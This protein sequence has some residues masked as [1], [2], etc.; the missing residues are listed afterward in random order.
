MF[1]FDSVVGR[2]VSEVYG[3]RSSGTSRMASLPRPPV[4]RTAGR[5][6]Y[7][8]E[9][10]GGLRSGMQ[11]RLTDGQSGKLTAPFPGCRGDGDW[12]GIFLDDGSEANIRPASVA[13]VFEKSGWRPFGGRVA[14]P[15]E[16][17][18]T[19]VYTVEFLDHG[20][21][22]MSAKVTKGEESAESGD[23]DDAAELLDAIVTFE[24]NAEAHVAPRDPRLGGPRTAPEQETAPG[25]P[26]L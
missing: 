10:P 21:D 17:G 14:A 2:V 8:W 18:K 5:N 7:E 19:V 24:M 22:R 15:T 13:S 16:P 4:S 20:T 3:S 26:P 23:L 12:C 6:H 25:E 1:D 11:V 9:M